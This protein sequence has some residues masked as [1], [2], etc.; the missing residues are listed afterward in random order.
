MLGSDIKPS[1]NCAT[2]ANKTTE[3][4]ITIKYPSKTV[5][6]ILDVQYELLAKA[7]LYDPP[8]R[9]ATAVMKC[10]QICK[11][12]VSKVFDNL[13]KEVSG[14]CLSK[15]PSLLRD[16][17]KEH[18]TN[19]KLESLGKEWKTRAPLFYLFIITSSVKKTKANSPWLPSMSLAGSIL[20]K[21]RDG[22]M[23]EDVFKRYVCL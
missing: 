23:N 10:P 22:K 17:N 2:I 19:F 4:E 3:V 13:G 7:L 14:L 15:K 18:L 16:T 21:Q 5:R 8:L 1:T 9:V 11:Y 6:H 20:L 12:V